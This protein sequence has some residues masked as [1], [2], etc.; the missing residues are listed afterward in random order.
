MFLISP[1]LEGLPCVCVCVLCMISKKLQSP[2]DGPEGKEG[3][4]SKAL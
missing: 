4:N 1:R 3:N 2:G